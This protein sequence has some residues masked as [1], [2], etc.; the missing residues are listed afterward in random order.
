MPSVPGPSAVL[1]ALERAADAAERLLAAVPQLA[2]LPAVVDRVVADVDGLITRIEATRVAADAVVARTEATRAKADG[3]IDVSTASV[4]RLVVMLDSLEPSVAKLQPTIER[5]ADTTDPRE[6]DALVEFIDHMPVLAEQVERDVLPV[7]R[8][9]S[10][11]APDLH[12]LLDV[13]RELNEMLGGSCPGMG[14]VKKR[15]EEQQQEDQ[16]D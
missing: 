2:A 10:S 12:D 11:V 14:R 5:L 6:V 13:S 3:L 7:M 15:V 8:T 16:G 4:E 1:S 9:L